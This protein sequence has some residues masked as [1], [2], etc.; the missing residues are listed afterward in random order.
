[1]KE[2]VDPRVALE[3]A[4]V[5]IARADLDVAPAALLERID[6]LER[7][8][9]RWRFRF[10]WRRAAGSVPHRRSGQGGRAARSPRPP[11]AK[12][13]PP[14]AARPSLRV[15]TAAPKPAPD[16]PVRPRPPA[17][18]KPAEPAATADDRRVAAAPDALPHPDQ[19]TLAWGDTILDQL[20]AA[21]KRCSAAGTSSTPPTPRSRCRPRST[22]N[23]ATRCGST[24]E[25]ALVAHF[26]RPL[27]L[28]LAVGSAAA[29]SRR[30]PNE[31][32]P[33]M[34]PN[35]TEDVGDVRELD[36]APPVASAVGPTDWRRSPVPRRKP[37]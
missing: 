8:A 3:T 27:T 17:R 18:P 10:R 2:A 1:M 12:Y 34:R 31:P 32:T 24:C 20:P 23:A 22:G 26:G 14:Q 5:R 25:Q 19:L 36:D 4:L 6:R 13:S 7:A 16:C 28:T 37:T 30:P 15:P 21:P 35:V 9:R 33:T 29:A 11:P